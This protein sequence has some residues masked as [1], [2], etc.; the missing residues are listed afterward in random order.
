ML[1]VGKIARFNAGR[2]TDFC[3][4]YLVNGA[5]CK[6]LEIKPN[7]AIVRFDGQNDTDIVSKVYL[8]GQ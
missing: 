6:V 2:R 7:T 4:S 8:K 1:T 3:R 5:K